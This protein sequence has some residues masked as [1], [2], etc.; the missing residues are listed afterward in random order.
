MNLLFKL[1]RKFGKYAIYNLM[2]Y[3]V[4]LYIFGL[5][6]S[7]FMPEVYYRYLA[8]DFAMIFKG[9]I[10]RLITFIIPVDTSYNFIFFIISVY[11]Y[12]II[13]NTLEH[14]WGAFRLN[15][16]FFSGVFF[17][18]LAG[19][20]SYLIN[21]YSY[22][23]T[24]SLDFICS[25]MFFAFA[26]L[27]PNTPFYIYFLI[28]IK[29]KWL[30]ILEGVV[31]LVSILSYIRQGQYIFTIPIIVAFL[32]FL[33]FFFAT[34][35]YRGISPS[36]LR[37]KATFR[38]NMDDAKRHGNVA[39]FRGRNVITRHK[40]AICGRTELDGDDLEFRFC[41]KCD[42]NYEYCMD[43]LFTHEHVKKPE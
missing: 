4:A 14:N 35:N 13:G 32:N 20:I 31:Y 39:Q 23:T 38:R 10:W 34:R 15:L 37:R 12:Y 42:G 24:S 2:L 5:A 9:Q 8:L 6:M 27:F 36:Q 7:V 19:L 25:T 40:C 17:N 33:I 43:H 11:F 3:I 16:Y 30:A 28:P 1:E 21:G 22:L 29:A 41:S 18:I 26:A